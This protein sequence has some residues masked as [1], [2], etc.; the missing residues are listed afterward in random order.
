M[1]PI[2][3]K[4][5]ERVVHNK[6]QEFLNENNL[7]YRYQSRFRKNYST[8]SC[9]S[10][11]CDK[12][13]KGFDSGVFTGMILIDLQKAFDNLNRVILSNTMYFGGFS[14]EVVSWFRTYLSNRDFKV[15]INKVL[16]DSGKVTC[17][18]PQGSII[19]LLLYA[20]G[21]CFIYQHHDI[22]IIEEKLNKDFSNIC[23]LF[24][25]NKLSIH[26]GEDKTKSILFT[27]KR[28][29]QL[30]KKLNITYNNIPIK[31]HASVSYLGCILDNTLS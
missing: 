17:G 1:L 27:S 25:D 13:L 7:I 2:V 26:F 16:S 4:I 10:Y 30:A 29:V 20:D 5:I 24:V 12:I 14:K 23:D 11:L 31:Q 18:V 21:T 6:T 8:N 3:S 15:S 28:K 19:E 22:D 9:L